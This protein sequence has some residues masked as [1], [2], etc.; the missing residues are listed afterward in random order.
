MTTGI[1]K[2]SFMPSIAAWRTLGKNSTSILA[3]LTKTKYSHVLIVNNLVICELKAT[4]ELND[5]HLAQ[6]NNYLRATDIELGLLFNF[7]L[8][9]DFERMIFSNRNKKFEK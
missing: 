2:H 6:L 5:T 1:R 7:G 9:P 4:A 3:H 8:K